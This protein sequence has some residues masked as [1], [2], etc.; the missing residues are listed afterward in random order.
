MT[1]FGLPARCGR[2]VEYDTPDEL[3]RLFSDHVVTTKA[4]CLGG[5]SNMLFVNGFSDKTFLRCTNTGC[6]VV[7]SGDETYITCGAGA[8]LDD[9]CHLAATHNLWG[10]E[11]LSGIPGTVGGAAVQNAGAYGVEIA[12]VLENVWVYTARSH[13]HA[14]ITP[15]QLD[16]GY[17]HSKFKDEKFGQG[18]WITA[19]TIKA[20]RQ[21][22]PNISY[23]GLTEALGL[24][25]SP[26]E[27]EIASLTPMDIRRAVIAVREAKLPS[28]ATTGSAG[29]FFKNPV[30]TKEEYARAVS[31]STTEPPYHP[32]PDGLCKLSAAWLIDHAGCKGM[33]VGGAALWPTQ[34]L[35]IVNANGNATGSDVAGLCARI[36]Q[37]VDLK[38]GISLKPEVLFIT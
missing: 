34:P 32:T 26:S 9:V 24:G 14:P 3:D 25:D 13:R 38:F 31:L 18:R 29:S 2:L 30:L 36:Q 19:V 35:V 28:P 33:H 10:L 20:T 22:R 15:D 17:R 37:A 27:A 5:G 1:T 11:N 6:R 23:K 8:L 4:I 7:D 16:Y 21:R 12:D